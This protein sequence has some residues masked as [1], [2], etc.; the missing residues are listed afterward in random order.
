MHMIGQ[1]PPPTIHIRVVTGIGQPRRR[2][3][4]IRR[5]S[6]GTLVDR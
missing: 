6:A 3:T 2:Q 1:H 5:C 4:Q